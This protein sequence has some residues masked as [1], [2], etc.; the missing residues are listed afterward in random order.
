MQGANPFTSA[1]RTYEKSGYLN[2]FGTDG[3]KFG[4]TDLR[5]VEIS[6]GKKGQDETQVMNVR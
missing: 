4:E 2:Y 6:E 1:M 3:M 5:R